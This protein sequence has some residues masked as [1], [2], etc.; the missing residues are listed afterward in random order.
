MFAQKISAHLAKLAEKYPEI[1]RQF[2]LPPCLNNPGVSKGQF[3]GFVDPLIE[4]K[5]M[6]VKGLV[7]K[8]GNRAL[9]L[10]TMVCAAYCRFCTRQRSVSDIKK[11]MISEQDLAKMVVYVKNHPKIKEI[12]FSGGD[13]LMVPEILK[14]ALIKFSGLAQIKIIRIGTRVPVSEPRLVSDGLLQAFRKVKQP[15][16][17]MVHFEHPAELTPE[18]VKAVERLRKTGAILFSQSVFLKGVNDKV[19]VLEELFSKLVEIGVKPYYIFRCDPVKGS[20]SFWVEPEREVE[21]MTQLRR[22]LSGLANPTYVIDTPNGSGK[23]PVPLDFWKFERD[24]YK[25]FTG[26]EQMLIR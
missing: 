3:S 9:V 11:G 12:I 22:K 18:T 21:I 5:F 24:S 20:E 10:L 17:I 23:I 8:Y 7:H 15:L 1:K 16:Y 13:P 4:E 6:P 26:K 25:D 2:S 19:E 14:S